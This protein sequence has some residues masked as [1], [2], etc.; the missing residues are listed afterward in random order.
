MIVFV[1]GSYAQRP[2]LVVNF[3][4]IQPDSDPP[5]VYLAFTLSVAL[6]H[7]HA[8]P[9]HAPPVPPQPTDPLVIAYV[10]P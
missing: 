8:P 6:V 10:V 1:G 5:A 3:K 7:V 4:V 9:L 2:P